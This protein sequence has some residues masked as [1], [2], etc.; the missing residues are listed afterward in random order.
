MY[1]FPKSIFGFKKK[2]EIIITKHNVDLFTEIICTNQLKIVRSREFKKA[3][4]DDKEL[5]LLTH[6]TKQ[7]Y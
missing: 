7:Q 4:I 1:S 2:L 3:I 5:V 6:L